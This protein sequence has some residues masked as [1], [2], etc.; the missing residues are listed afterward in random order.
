MLSV[1]EAQDRVL[2]H[3]R[4]TATETVSLAAA[5]RRV[6]AEDVHAKASQPPFAAS[7]MDGYAVRWADIQTVPVQLMPVGESAAGRRFAGTCGPGEAVRIFTGAPLPPG[8]DTVVVQEDAEAAPGHVRILG[9]PERSG[10]HIRAAGAD[11]AAGDLLLRK[12]T[13]LSARDIAL[14]AAA[15]HA[16]LCVFARPKVAMLT[17]GDELRAPGEPVGPDQIIAS[18][19]LALAL[20]LHDAGADVTDL[21]IVPDALEPL[22]AALRSAAD[23]DLIITI[24]GASV[25]DKDLTRAALEACGARLAFWKIAMRPGKPLML[26]ELP[27]VR[28]DRPVPVLGLPGNPVSALVCALLFALPLVRAMQG[29]PTA[30][31]LPQVHSGRLAVP[32]TANGPRA[33][34][35][36]AR[37]H[38]EAGAMWVT[39]FADQDS[40][41]LTVLSAANALAIRAPD[42]PPAEADTPIPYML[43]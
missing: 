8:A 36:R 39:P 11:F 9:R 42:A 41:R 5:I 17:S 33:H 7:A 14:A 12:G 4:L 40:A 21:G 34:Y 1:D 27:G 20:L 43:L 22:C 24:G 35:L 10:G 30:D 25:G 26:A 18:N 2:A 16:G 3:A 31:S 28:E 15:H 37:V 19:S 38:E 13:R 29:V 6:L 32:L 23:A